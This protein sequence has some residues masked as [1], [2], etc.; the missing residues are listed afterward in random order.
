MGFDNRAADR[1]AHAH[2]VGFRRVEGFRVSSALDVRALVVFL[3]RLK[4]HDNA[5]ATKAAV[6][7]PPQ[8][9]PS[10]FLIGRPMDHLALGLGQR[11]KMLNNGT[12]VRVSVVEEWKP[13]DLGVPGLDSHLPDFTDSSDGDGSMIC[14]DMKQLNGWLRA[15]LAAREETGP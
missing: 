12:M 9:V 7:L 8:P 4:E 1:E 3:D 14:I 11:G 5:V 15:R 13:S 10:K 2:A 6:K